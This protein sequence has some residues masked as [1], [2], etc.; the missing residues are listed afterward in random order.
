MGEMLCILYLLNAKDFHAENVICCGAY[1]YLVD[2]E[3]LLHASFF[4]DGVVIEGA[5]NNALNYVDDSV[6][7]TGLLPVQIV[8]PKTNIMIEIG[9]MGMSGQQESPFSI[10]EASEDS[11]GEIVFHKKHE[12]I[13]FYCCHPS[14]NSKYID[15]VL[16]I[17]DV[18]DGFRITYDYISKNKEKFS[19]LIKKAFSD[20]VGRIILRSTNIYSQLIETSY[21]PLL[22]EDSICRK[23]F[24]L[25]LF[26]SSIVL[27]DELCVS[28]LSDMYYNDI[29]FFWYHSDKE[30]IYDSCGGK[31]KFV[32][33]DTMIN[34]AV[35]KINQMCDIDLKCQ[36]S[37]I[38]I[39]FLDEF[40]IYKIPDNVCID[41]IAA[42]PLAKIN[43]LQPIEYIKRILEIIKKKSFSDKN[44]GISKRTWLE[45]NRIPE[46]PNY[47]SFITADL[48]GGL[49]GL[50]LVLDK[51]AEL[52]D[53][54]IAKELSED[55]EFDLLNNFSEIVSENTLKFGAFNGVLG[56]VYWLCKKKNYQEQYLSGIQAVINSIG[57][58]MVD[59]CDIILGKSG[60][61]KVLLLA[62]EKLSLGED[63]NRK[64][65]EALLQLKSQMIDKAIYESDDSVYWGVEG[66]VGYAHGVAG[67]IDALADYYKVYHDDDVL[68][69][70][71]SGYNYI[72]KQFSE[73][74][75][76][77]Q[78]GLQKKEYSKGWCHGAPGIALLQCNLIE[79]FDE[80]IVSKKD[81]KKS[82]EIIIANGFGEDFCMCHGDS[83]NLIILKKCANVL[84]DDEL[85]KVCHEKLDDMLNSMYDKIFGDYFYY[86]E[87]NAL[88]LGVVSIITAILDINYDMN[89]GDVL[90]L[91]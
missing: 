49:S 75:N 71:T 39:S 38:R 88:M 57:N 67:I 5:C 36:I 34:K 17:D 51:C 47:V 89:I 66:F 31:K 79:I 60:M 72:S 4:K 53:D 52:L 77:W 40:D 55:I 6:L 74:T 18:I 85:L 1:P 69:Y 42:L 3:T 50:G 54:S 68:F 90:S 62:R 59:D 46:Y 25:K 23:V 10:T 58:C 33:N 19:L 84:S 7:K 41:N 15:A 80:K 28:E 16:Y 43:Q 65:D 91:H 24:L 83:G 30:Y 2:L 78:K 11:N 13:S 27:D 35:C 56:I 61:M 37:F 14:I 70:V 63:V 12:T 20:V 73:T 22:L 64:I 8:N 44:S 9:A 48:Y 76:N 82:C 26:E 45:V 81:L 87:N 32:L 86:F 29:P 21:H